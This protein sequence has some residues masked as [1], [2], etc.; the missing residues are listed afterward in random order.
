MKLV[1]TATPSETHFA[2]IMIRSPISENFPKAQ[3]F[4]FDAIEVHLRNPHDVDRD[5]IYLS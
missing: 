2:L 3:D 5:E 1:I 4:G